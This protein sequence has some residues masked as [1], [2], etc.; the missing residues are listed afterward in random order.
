MST[1]TLLADGELTVE[2]RVVTASNL[3]LYARV[4]APDGSTMPCVYK[5][6]SG[7]RPLW[8]FPDGTLAARERAAFLVSEAGG[9]HLVPATVLR[10][11]PLGP[12][13]CQEWVSSDVDVDWVRVLDTDDAGTAPWMPVLRG[14][15]ERGRTVTLAH[16][17]DPSLRA[18]ALLDAVLNNA[19]RKGGHLLSGPGGALLGVDHG[20]C[21][22]SEPKLRTVLWGWRG[23]P[24]TAGERTQLL[25]LAEWL[26]TDAGELDDLLAD[27]ESAAL[28]ARVGALLDSGRLPHPSRSWP[29]IPW[30][31]I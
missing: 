12:G 7:E 2:G 14:Q 29:A 8:D 10:D 26:D 27:D 3:T 20:L 5:P 1:P 16:R 19:D 25:G 28:R 22:H 18:M 13:M 23:E 11:G 15:D 6:V 21:C 9:W 17:D 30:P 4:D 24:L 31:A